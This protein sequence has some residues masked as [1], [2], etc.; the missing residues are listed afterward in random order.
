MVADLG[1]RR[2]Y[3]RTLGITSQHL[4]SLLG[5]NAVVLD[6]FEMVRWMVSQPYEG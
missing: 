6:I 4:G 5:A 2:W 3:N 1:A